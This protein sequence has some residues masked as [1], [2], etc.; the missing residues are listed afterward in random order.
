MGWVVLI[1]SAYKH[2]QLSFILSIYCVYKGKWKKGI[3]FFFHPTFYHFV[4]LLTAPFISQK[5]LSLLNALADLWGYFLYYMYYMT[6]LSFG[7]EGRIRWGRLTISLRSWICF[8]YIFF[9]LSFDLFINVHADIML[10]GFFLM[11]YVITVFKDLLCM[12]VERNLQ[13]KKKG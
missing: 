3:S 8:P 11:E 7:S 10:L 6:V 13:K 5:L 1:S 2:K 9:F 4:F 12:Y